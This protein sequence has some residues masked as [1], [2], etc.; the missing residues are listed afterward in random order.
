M[1]QTQLP[2]KKTDKL[3]QKSQLYA[4]ASAQFEQAKYLVIEQ[5]TTL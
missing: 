1:G 3:P 4:T 2:A 5:I